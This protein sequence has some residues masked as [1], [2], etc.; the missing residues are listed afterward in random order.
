MR[1][2]RTTEHENLEE[3]VNLWYKHRGRRLLRDRDSL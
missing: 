1:L 2:R 3:R